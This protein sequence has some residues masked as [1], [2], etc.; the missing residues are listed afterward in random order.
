MMIEK[1][2]N[3]NTFCNQDRI[4]DDDA[5]RSITGSLTGCVTALLFRHEADEAFHSF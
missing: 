4:P 1:L 2:L 5:G 3:C